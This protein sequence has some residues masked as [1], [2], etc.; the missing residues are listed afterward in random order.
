MK[1]I[2]SKDGTTIACWHSGHGEPLL[3]IH[4]TSGDHAG[5]TLLSAELESHFQVWTMDRRGR[6]DSGDNSVYSLQH[7]A[8]DIAAVIQA[9]GGKV[10][11]FG[12]SFGGLCA[13][14]AALLTENLAS[15]ILYEPPLSLTGSGW[16]AELDQQM[17]TLLNAGEKEQ[18][19]LLFFRQVLRMSNEELFALQMGTGWSARVAEAHTV[20]RELQAIDNYQFDAA[21]FQAFLTP[22]LLLLGSDSPSRRHQIADTLKNALPNSQLVLLENQQHSAVRTAPKLLASKILKFK[23]L[24]GF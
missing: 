5:W 15:L 9:I 7:E 6:G 3:L 24:S 4:G 20:H 2:T 19:V 23:D 1:H 18:V 14:E 21:K 10:H 8:E 12:H 11:V 22:A 13:L 16:S 17:Q